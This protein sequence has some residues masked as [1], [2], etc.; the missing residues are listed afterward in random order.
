M[1]KQER[2]FTFIELLVSLVIASM[3]ILVATMM[4]TQLLRHSVSNTNRATVIRQVQNVGLW[5]GKDVINSHSVIRGTLDP[6]T[7]TGVFLTVNWDDWDGFQY[8]A[9]YTVT[10]GG[11]MQRDLYADGTLSHT[12]QVAQYLDFTGSQPTRLEPSE[13][14]SYTLIVTATIASYSQA[15]SE[16]RTYEILPRLNNV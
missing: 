15:I 6:L 14:A 7:H 5:I 4:L 16:T 2:G 12:A 1:N 13:N 8:Q 10:T 11:V 9:I 3:I